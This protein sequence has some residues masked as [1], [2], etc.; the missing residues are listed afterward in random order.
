MFN[1]HTLFLTEDISPEIF[2][3][4]R[5]SLAAVTLHYQAH[6]LRFMSEG[7]LKALV[8]YELALRIDGPYGITT[9]DT[10]RH[11]Q[12]H[13]DWPATVSRKFDVAI[14]DASEADWAGHASTPV[15]VC[16]LTRLRLPTAT[17]GIGP[18]L[19]RL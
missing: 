18:D 8:H 17:P 16:F 10:S 9:A 2:P 11:G 19:E 15:R 3:P 5:E 14:A 4:L 12:V 1:G 7:D 13:C 6:P